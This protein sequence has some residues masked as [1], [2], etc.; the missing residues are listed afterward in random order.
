M[1]DLRELSRG[2]CEEEEKRKCRIEVG[3]NL[4]AVCAK[5]P[6]K[7]Q[8]EISDYTAK[9]LRVRSMRLAGY[10]IRANDLTHEEWIDLGKIEA[11]L[12]RGP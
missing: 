4:D 5:C 3:D 2:V 9:L 6:K 12:T 8:T 10:P 11:W 7:R 1:E